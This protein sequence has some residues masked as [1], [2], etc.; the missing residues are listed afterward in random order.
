MPHSQIKAT[1]FCVFLQENQGGAN[2][3]RQRYLLVWRRESGY[4][5]AMKRFMQVMLTC[6]STA[7]LA[8]AGS[9]IVSRLEVHPGARVLHAPAKSQQ[10]T[11]I[12]HFNDG[13][14]RNVTRLTAFSSSDAEIASVNENGLATFHKPGE[15]AILCRYR[16]TTTRVRLSHVDPKPGYRWSAPPEVNFIDKHAFA[17]RE[18]L[19]IVPADLC[20]DEHFV[21]RAYLD[22]CG[23]LPT[24]DETRKFLADPAKDKRSRLIDRLLSRPEYGDF[25]TYHWVESLDINVLQ[26]RGKYA[27]AFQ[28][29]I[30]EHVLKNTPLDQFVCEILTARG[31]IDKNPAV[32]YYAPLAKPTEMAEHTALA[33][34]GIRLQCAACHAHFD[35]PWTQDDYHGFSAFFA[36]VS[37]KTRKYPERGIDLALERKSE[38]LHP[39]TRKIVP[40]RPLGGKPLRFEQGD[41]RREAL[42]AWIVGK[43]NPHFARAQVNRIW[44]KLFSKGIVEPIDDFR[45]SNP[46]A[47]DELLDALAQGFIKNRFDQKHVIRTIM[48]SRTY[49]LSAQRNPH[50]AA[51]EKYFSRCITSFLYGEQFADAVAAFTEVPE[52][53]PGMPAGTRFVQ[54]LKDRQPPFLSISRPARISPCEREHFLEQERASKQA[55]IFHFINGEEVNKRLVARDNRL[56]RLLKDRKLTDKEITEELFLAAYSRLPTATDWDVVQK[57]LLRDN[58]DRRR[59][60]EDIMWALINS[61]EF[62]RR[63]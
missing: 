6:L 13:S 4:S 27:V 9:P 14:S 49:Q 51:D 41:D 48:N 34:L 21:R 60:F 46:S 57:H 38:W 25:W 43:D 26:H 18:R 50:N 40:A 47:N 61:A 32:A 36:Q 53:F 58:L 7:A 5:E 3:V 11:V 16:T 19:K 29:W 30:R 24:P 59:A 31:S 63:H 20:S 15:V 37:G 35:T 39:E 2:H 55:L 44:S 22:A 12:A 33:F 10:F 62:A 54:V 17:Q 23:I 28:G 45:M 52:Q 42:A 8:H 56:G 1:F